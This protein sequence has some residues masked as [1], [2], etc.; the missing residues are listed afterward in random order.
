MRI[1]AS[2]NE[3][4]KLIKFLKPIVR[5]QK[6]L[7][8]GSA[9]FS[10]F[11]SYHPGMKVININGSSY[12]NSE[13]GIH[14]TDITFLDC[15]VL[16]PTINGVKENRRELFE[17][18]IITATNLGILVQTQSNDST[19]G[20]PNAYG[21]RFDNNLWM[22]RFTRRLLLLLLC[23]NFYIESNRKSLLSTGGIAL[24]TVALL[25]PKS[26]TLSGFSF[27][28]S[29]NAEDPP[30]AYNSERQ[31]SFTDLNDT[32]S[33]SSADSFLISFLSLR[34]GNIF[35]KDRDLLPLI[36]NWGTKNE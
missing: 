31:S 18:R 26:I 5:N 1:Y 2:I 27:F 19:G 15:E 17:N 24:A 12:R 36:H 3:L 6:V 11:N 16:D 13:L 9:P 29:I 22:N 21:L 7:L 10:N 30:K 28:K 34:D 20:D 8:V 4:I 33:H 23:R 25:K 35:S 32:R 14:K